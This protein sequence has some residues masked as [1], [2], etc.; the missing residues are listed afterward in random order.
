MKEENKK[1]TSKK[2]KNKEENK[3]TQSFG[4]KSVI[5]NKNTQSFDKKNII[6]NK[7]IQSLDKKLATKK[8]ERKP[9]SDNDKKLLNIAFNILAVFCIAIFCIALTPKTLQNDTFYTI[10]V[11]QGIREWGIDGQDHYSFINLPYTYPHWLY[12]VIMSL[13]FDFLGGWTALYVSTMVLSCLLGILLYFTLKKVTKNSLISFVIALGQM[14][15]MK[16]YIAARAQL[17]TFVLFVLTVLFIEKFLES[18]KKRYAVGLIIIPILIAN[19]HSAVWPFYFVLFLPYIGEYIIRII[20]DAHIVHNVYKWITEFRIKRTNKILKKAPKESVAKYQTKVAE[21]TKLQEENNSKFEITLTKRAEKRKRPF[22]LKIEKLDRVKWLILIM[23]ICLFTGLLTPIGDMPY[24][25]TL[26]IMQGNTTSNISEH[27]PLT[28]IDSKSTLFCLTL[29]IAI[30]IFTDSKIRLRDLFF[31]A[32]LTLLALMSRRQVSMLVLFGGIVF[33]RILTELLERFDKKGTKEVMNFMTS[34]IGEILTILFIFSISYFV[35]IPNQN[36]P[37]VDTGSYPVEAAEWIKEN[38]DYKNIR[39]FNEYNYGSYLLF[40]DIPVFIDSRCDLYTP[41]FN[42]EKGE[43]GK[44]DG[45]DVFTDFINISSIATYY[46]TKFEQYDITHV[47]TKTNTKLN[48]LLS[49][50]DGY[51]Q[52][53]KDDDF[54]IYERDTE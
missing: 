51:T 35:Y 37:Y 43:D 6:E 32:G 22:K 27:L 29:V 5:E 40:E 34:T 47:M 44:Y 15:L 23:F 18:G 31:L 1:D 20:L 53:Y 19:I 24:T 48:M 33:A 38:L 12:D 46:D 36:Q 41:E 9:M 17:V 4:K 14:F 21:L 16:D 25:Y 13:L 30:L 54:I 3:N 10:K 2:E 26:K 8:I 52:I 49:R 42:G 50:D 45:I 39:M 11:G 7:K 28:L